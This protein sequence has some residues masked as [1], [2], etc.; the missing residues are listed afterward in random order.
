M[1]R[2]LIACCKRLLEAKA[3][4]QTSLPDTLVQYLHQTVKDRLEQEMTTVKLAN[5]SRPDFDVN[6]LLY[7]VHLMKL[8]R[9]SSKNLQG[10]GDTAIW[11]PAEWAIV[12][13]VRA[14]P[15]GTNNQI[16]MLNEIDKASIYLTMT[17]MPNCITYLERESQPW[18]GTEG[19]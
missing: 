19:H 18:G 5:H 6:I 10:K 17:R 2:L 9:C 15:Q 12:Y 11:D 14:D 16:Y 3:G 1:R 8:K 7:K 4:K 13:V